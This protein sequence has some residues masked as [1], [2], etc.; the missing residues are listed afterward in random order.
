[1]MCFADHSHYPLG[2]CRHID[3]V[4]IGCTTAAVVVEPTRGLLHVTRSNPC[5]NWPVT[6]TL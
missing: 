1:M 2:I 4:D 3:G 6:Y 5:A